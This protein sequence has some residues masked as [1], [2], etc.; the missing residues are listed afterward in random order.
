M[1]AVERGRFC[2]NCQK[3]V[4]DFTQMDYVEV[5]DFL[6]VNN[7]GCGRFRNEQPNRLLQTAQATPKYFITPFYK[8]IAASLLFFTAFAKYPFALFQGKR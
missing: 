8:K 5:I 3:V 4:T 2:N 6:K 1:T 7:T